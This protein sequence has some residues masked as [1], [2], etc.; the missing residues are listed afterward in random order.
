MIELLLAASMSYYM[1]T[2]CQ[3]APNLTELEIKH[4][5][6]EMFPY[7]MGMNNHNKIY[8]YGLSCKSN[9]EKNL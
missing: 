6:E 9:G 7:R 2:I 4:R 5:S 1:S 3:E 8:Y